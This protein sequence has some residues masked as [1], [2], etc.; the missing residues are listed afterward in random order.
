MTCPCI[1][2]Y[3]KKLTATNRYGA[4]AACAVLV[5]AREPELKLPPASMFSRI[6]TYALQLAL[7]WLSDIGASAPKGILAE[8]ASP[9]AKLPFLR[10]HLSSR[11]CSF[12][13]SESRRASVLRHAV[14][15]RGG[16][17][18]QVRQERTWTRQLW[19]RARQMF[20]SVQFRSNCCATLCSWPL[21]RR[22]RATEL[23]L[24]LLFMHLSHLARGPAPWLLR[25]CW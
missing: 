14:L 7:R 1:A 9:A 6:K 5:L 8:R 11:G 19:R 10:K 24:C 20:F 13:A 3:F 25:V 16:A 4:P 22:A 18:V 23:S 12:A 17:Y 21:G 15:L 2:T